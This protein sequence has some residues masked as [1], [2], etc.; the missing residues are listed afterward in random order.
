MVPLLEIR[1]LKK[2][3]KTKIGMLHAVDGVSVTLDEGK[4]LGVVGE[5]GCGKTTLGRTILHLIDLTDGQIF[6]DGEDITHP[7]EK[8]LRRLREKMQIV[9]QDPFSSLNPRMSVSD[10]IME[11]LISA[12]GYVQGGYAHRDA[13]DYGYGWYRVPV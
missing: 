1:D 10:A 5:S 8:Q 12:R 3:F 4:T 2:Y 7:S 13:Q 9:F 6:F 11:P